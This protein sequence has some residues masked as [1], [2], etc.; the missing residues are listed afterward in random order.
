LEIEYIPINQ[1]KIADYNPREAR[2]PEI[3]QGIIETYRSRNIVKP[4]LVRKIRDGEYEVFDGGTRL[5]ALKILNVD[6]APCII[7]DCSRREAMEMAAIVHT[8]REELTPAEKGK[9]I[10]RCINE[11]IWRNVEEAARALGFSK[12]TLYDWIKEARISSA[13]MNTGLRNLLNRDSRKAL[14]S[15]PKPVREELINELASL[16]EE[17]AGKIKRELPNIL[18]EIVE[19]S[20]ELEPEEVLKEFRERVSKIIESDLDYSV[21]FRASSGYMYQ[22]ERVGNNVVIKVLSKTSSADQLTIP[23]IDVKELV[24]RLSKFIE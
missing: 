7:Y 19:I 24:R 23:C 8:N 6:K 22:L 10:L 5:E 9:F 15:M 20:Y 18:N 12:D 21:I 17:I 1:L 13:M 11:G 14:A 16:T 2:S 4:L 3:I